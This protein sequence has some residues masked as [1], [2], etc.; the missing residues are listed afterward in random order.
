M[1]NETP[2]SLDRAFM[3]NSD[4]NRFKNQS[5]VIQEASFVDVL[6]IHSHPLRKLD[7]TAAACLPD[8]GATGQHGEALTLPSIAL[9]RLTDRQR[10][11]PNE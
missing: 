8:A 11:W 10:S 3:K 7:V 5:H 4:V 2:F 1:L 9:L 6:E